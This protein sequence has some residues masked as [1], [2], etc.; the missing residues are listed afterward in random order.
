MGCSMKSNP[1]LATIL[2]ICMYLGLSDG[3]LAIYQQGRPEPEQVL[4]YH[5]DL[6]TGH[7][8]SALETGIPFRSADELAK[9][10]EDYTG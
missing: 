4:P 2:I 9:L 6:Y 1:L 8:R 7:D 3:Y 10:L 5:V